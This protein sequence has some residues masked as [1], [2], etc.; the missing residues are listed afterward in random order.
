[1]AELTHYEVRISI[2]TFE[3]NRDDF[4]KY[5]DNV[6]GTAKK[7]FQ[8]FQKQEKSKCQEAAI[9]QDQKNP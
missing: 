9:D 4:D 6:L 7:R 3:F 8:K 1:M 2:P 5:L